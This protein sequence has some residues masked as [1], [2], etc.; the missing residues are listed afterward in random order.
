MQ[1]DLHSEKNKSMSTKN[2]EAEMQEQTDRAT[3]ISL[4]ISDSKDKK[5]EPGNVIAAII[6]RHLG[7]FQK[8]DLKVLMTDYTDDSVF[9]T[10]TETY[11]GLAEIELFFKGLMQHFPVEGSS[12]SLDKFVIDKDLAYIIWHA[13]TPSLVIPLGTDTFVIKNNK[14]AQQTFAGDL[15]FL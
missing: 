13:K 6:S 4:T 1:V 3:E 7:S 9:I 5:V 8:N 11:K 12:F 10:Q 15:R 14:I 2:A